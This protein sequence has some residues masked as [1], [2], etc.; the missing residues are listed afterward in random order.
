MTN[1]SSR[2]WSFP[3]PRGYWNRWAWGLLAAQWGLI[4][5]VQSAFRL[6]F[7]LRYREIFV[8]ASAWEVLAAFLHG[9][10]FDASVLLAFTGPAALAFF[11]LSPWRLRRWPF[12]LLFAWMAGV[13]LAMFVLQG[14]DLFYYGFVGRRISFEVYA[15]LNDW[16]PILT[17]AG[18]AYLLP[19]VLILALLAV[20]LT[21]RPG[22]AGG[23]RGAP[24]SRCP[25][26]ASSAR[27]CCWRS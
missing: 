24:T 7:Y 4:L 22:G 13:A 1:P 21:W 6:A 18:A 2:D 11:L 15:M 27:G 5:G 14:M 16:R 20:L 3:S 12:W 19:T 8:G 10:R 23:W 25:G 9:L 17:M 26:G